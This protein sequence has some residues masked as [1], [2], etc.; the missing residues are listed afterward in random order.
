MMKNNSLKV[1]II[2]VCRNSAEFL[3]KMIESA[4]NQDYEEK[5]IFIQDGGSTDGTLDILKCYPIDWI[6]ESDNGISHAFNKA[7]NATNGDIIGFMCADDG[8]LP[9][10]ITAIVEVFKKAPDVIMVYG[11]CLLLNNKREPYRIWKGE[12]FDLDLLFW[13][14]FIPF[15]TVYVRRHALYDVGMFDEELKL[16]Q[17]WDLW[18]RLGVRFTD[19]YFRYIPKVLG[20]YQFSHDYKSTGSNFPLH[21]ECQKKV[22]FRFFNDPTSV[23]KLKLGKKRALAGANLSLSSS[24]YLAAQG[25]LAWKKYGL[26]IQLFPKIVFM[27]YNFFILTKLIFGMRFW[28][29]YRKLKIRWCYFSKKKLW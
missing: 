16:V 21:A 17:D 29:L 25:S 27:K 8:L 12:P 3:P 26:A 6:S 14:N 20:Y 5:K 18:L 13:K 15:Q 23:A 4:L 2:A 22:I 19:R 24:Y 9:G 7:I 28:V 11:D 10:A 1:D